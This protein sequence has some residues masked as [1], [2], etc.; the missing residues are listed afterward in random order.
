MQ[1]AW[2]N[3]VFVSGIP[4]PQ[5]RQSEFHAF[6]CHNSINSR[7]NCGK[8]L[9]TN[10]TMKK[11]ISILLI[12]ILAIAFGC[13]KDN[14][15]DNGG[16]N[17]SNN[18]APTCTIT[19]PQNGTTFSLSDNIP[20]T[21]SAADPD[22]TIAEV[23]LSIDD[24]EYQ[25]ATSSPYN[26]TITSGIVS[27]GVHTI[28]AIA[29]DNNETSA[30]SSI[31][32]IIEGNPSGN[33][34][35][36]TCIIT[37]PQDGTTFAYDENINVSVF[38]EDSDGSIEKVSLY[39]DNVGY[40]EMTIFPYNF[41]I[42]SGIMSPGTHTIKAIAKDNRGSNGESSVTITIEEPATESPD[43]VSFSDG[44]IP[45]TWQTATWYVDNTGGYDDIYSLKVVGEG[46]VM[47]TKTIQGK[48]YLEF[49]V[50]SNSNYYF[51]NINDNTP[52]IKLYIDGNT[53][54]FYSEETIGSW[55]KYIVDVKE[56][57]HT[58]LWEYIGTNN[59]NYCNIDV[60]RF[61][62]NSTNPQ[63]GEFYQGGIVAY[64]DS[65]REHGL[66]LSENV[67]G[68][69]NW[70]N[71]NAACNNYSASQYS[72]W[73]LPTYGEAK[74]ITSCIKKTRQWIIPENTF[75][76]TSTQTGNNGYYRLILWDNYY[77]QG[78]IVCA[79]IETEPDELSN[80]RAIRSF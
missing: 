22:G 63:I 21:V 78:N 79:N 45:P 64:L 48:G 3:F 49:Y 57:I 13:T 53:F 51:N 77:E 30:E 39:I 28:K 15:N 8:L 66:V 61:T 60:I 6:I 50:K 27:S 26:F 55:K 62:H 37:S 16:G 76:W 9:M 20:V 1:F 56:G 43:F 69:Y 7:W 67:L 74:D 40:S 46:S 2:A 12:G 18:T 65:S 41:T 44:Q 23:K 59:L 54:Y 47:T 11:P 73:R 68:I 75:Y 14:Q 17:S 24:M 70:E 29:K 31:V 38:A 52:S 10:K 72:D 58:F 25:A 34:V 32:V 36:P 71:A 19:S 80:T 33:N 42:P 5:N 35:A 4:E